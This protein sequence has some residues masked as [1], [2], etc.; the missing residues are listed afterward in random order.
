[1]AENLAEIL[2]HC[3]EDAVV[4]RNTKG[5]LYMVCQGCGVLHYAAPKGQQYL[6]G[7]MDKLNEMLQRL[8][9]GPEVEL[10]EKLKQ[11]QE[12][13]PVEEDEEDSGLLI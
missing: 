5:K 9:D 13:R 10:E 4:R 12:A 11:K 7:E 8:E 1:M 2:H 6:Q 3:G